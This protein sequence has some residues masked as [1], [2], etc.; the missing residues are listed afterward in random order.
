[1]E[2]M[3]E[4][5][6]AEIMKN[7]MDDFREIQDCMLLAKEESAVKTYAKLKDKYLTLKALLNSLGVNMTDIDRIKESSQSVM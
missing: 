3:E 4:M 7:A 2:V 5:N 6:N 1:M